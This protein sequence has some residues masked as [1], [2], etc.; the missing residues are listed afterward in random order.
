MAMGADEPTLLV[1]AI[2]HYC[3]KARWALD[4]IGIRHHLRAVAPGAHVRV[5]RRLGA[6]ERT[7]PL[8][9]LADGTL[10]QGS[11]QII[12]WAIAEH[13]NGRVSGAA[14]PTGGDPMI[15]ARLDD[16]F[17]G[18]LVHWYYSET[19]PVAPRGMRRIFS[20]GLGT[21][22]RIGLRLTWPVMRRAM[23]HGMALG[24]ERARA[25]LPK[26]EAELDW[27]DGLVTGGVL[28]AA[29]APPGRLEITAA[30][31]LAPI[32]LPPEH[33]HYADLPIPPALRRQID[34]WQDRPCFGWTR[35]L[36]AQHRWAHHR[37]ARQAVSAR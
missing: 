3:E 37:S 19:L 16:R 36:Y 18:P 34:A 4:R 2:S 32:V 11:S 12:D 21:V 31:L 7:V 6:A 33:P 28:A 23:V 17:A 13:A 26:I 14:L 1:F 29:E 15:E 20:A 24:P 35:T 9:H 25:E 10:I 8:L 27:I 30:A 22:E 5:L